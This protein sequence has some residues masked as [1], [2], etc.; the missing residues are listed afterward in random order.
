[1]AKNTYRNNQ[2][3]PVATAPAAPIVAP[4][5]SLAKPAEKLVTVQNKLTQLLTPSYIGEDGQIKELRLGPNESSAP[6]PERKLTQYTT[7]LAA[8]GHLRIQQA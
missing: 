2:S 1:M 6:I 5:P 8:R 7:S 4:A 3:A